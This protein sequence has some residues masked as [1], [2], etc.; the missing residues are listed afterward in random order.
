MLALLLGYR[1]GGEISCSLFSQVQSMIPIEALQLCKYIG[2]LMEAMYMIA[3]QST[4]V[5][6]T[7]SGVQFSLKDQ[8]QQNAYSSHGEL[9]D[10]NVHVLEVVMPNSRICSPLFN[11]PATIELIENLNRK[12]QVKTGVDLFWVDIIRLD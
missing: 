6:L 11:E 8:E 3:P 7:A 4:G 12:I 2:R 9:E 1:H 5:G 10:D